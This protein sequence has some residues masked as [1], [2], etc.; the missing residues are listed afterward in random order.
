[1]VTQ[2]SRRK[3]AVMDEMETSDSDVKREFTSG[4]SSEGDDDEEDDDTVYVVEKILDQRMGKNSE[5]EYLIKWEGYA[6]SESTWEVEDNII[7]R[8]ILKKFWDAKNAEAEARKAKK[9]ATST[10][11]SASSTTVKAPVAAAKKPPANKRRR[12]VDVPEEERY[13]EAG[14]DSDNWE[15]LVREIETVDRMPNNDLIVFIVWKNG[16]TTEHPAEMAYTRCPQIMLKFYEERL[17]FRSR[18]I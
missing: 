18:D 9:A 5:K 17:R 10:A 4:V 12:T 13:G 8:S 6:D 3:A 2:N 15:P 7:D 11:A 14:P 1:M 16:Q